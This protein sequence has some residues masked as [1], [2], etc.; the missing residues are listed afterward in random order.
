M[1]DFT[2]ELKLYNE[3]IDTLEMKVFE[4]DFQ[5]KYNKMLLKKIQLKKRSLL[6]SYRTD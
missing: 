4:L 6:S 5:L 1:S 3:K 2:K